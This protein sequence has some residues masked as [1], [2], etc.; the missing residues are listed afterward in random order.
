MKNWVI[1]EDQE[2]VQ[3]VGEFFIQCTTIEYQLELIFNSYEDNKR[4]SKKFSNETFGGKLSMLSKTLKL[5]DFERRLDN[6]KKI[7]NRLAH[8][9][10]L[11]DPIK[12]LSSVKS[13]PDLN[14]SDENCKLSELL[15]DL[16]ALILKFEN[17]NFKDNLAVK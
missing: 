11:Y 17:N 14:M 8:D 12:K 3:Q 4:K 1:T 7:R 5:G 2:F 15:G 13:V 10:I 16:N 9:V 6:L